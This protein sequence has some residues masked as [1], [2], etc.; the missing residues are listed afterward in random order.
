MIEN[1]NENRKFDKRNWGQ[2]TGEANCRAARTR[3]IIASAALALNPTYNNKVNYTLF[4]FQA[5]S[6]ASCLYGIIL[7]LPFFVR[8]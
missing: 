5:S 4:R 7:L 3:R 8:T 2:Q 6:S 1:K